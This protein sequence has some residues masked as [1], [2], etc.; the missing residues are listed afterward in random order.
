MLLYLTKVS[1]S[2]VLPWVLWNPKFSSKTDYATHIYA[3]FFCKKHQILKFKKCHKFL[4]MIWKNINCFRSWWKTY[5][6]HCTSNYVIT[7]LKTLFPCTLQLVRCSQFQGTIWKMEE[8]HV[9]ENIELKTW[10]WKS[11]F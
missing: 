7:C 2:C 11:W 1:L 5:I 10:Q 9:S 4:I 8:C 6:K 3:F